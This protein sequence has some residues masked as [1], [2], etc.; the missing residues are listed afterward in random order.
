MRPKGFYNDRFRLEL[1][2]KQA[3]MENDLLFNIMTADRLQLITDAMKPRTLSAGAY[4]MIEGK[5]GSRFY[6]SIGGHFEVI[7]GQEVIKRFNHITVI[8]ESAM[9]SN[10]R[11]YTSIRGLFYLNLTYSV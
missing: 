10:V 4:L 7:K 11:R 6:V 5:I 2:L 3:I 9:L 1:L 8:G